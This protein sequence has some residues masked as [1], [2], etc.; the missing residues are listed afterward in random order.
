[1]LNPVT[2]TTLNYAVGALGA[3][4]DGVAGPRLLSIATR[5]E[6]SSLV[7]QFGALDAHLGR[8]APSG[9]F[10][11]LAPEFNHVLLTLVLTALAVAVLA[12]RR[13]H[14]NAQVSSLWR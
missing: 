2:A 6:S 10:D 5:L 4:A 11:V 1:M 12:L 9:G 3:T 14:H 13:A 7:L 8:A